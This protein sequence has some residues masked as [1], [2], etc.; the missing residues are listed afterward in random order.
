MSQQLVFRI[1]GQLVV[2]AGERTISVGGARQRTVLAMLLLSPDRVVS[3]DSLIKAVWQ[4]S[5]PSTS[6]NQIAICVSGLRKTFESEANVD[7]LIVTAHPGYILATGDHV[8]D[9]LEFEEEVR[10]GRELIRRGQ[11]AEAGAVLESALNLWRGPALDGINGAEEGAATLDEL[12]LDAYEELAGLRLQLGQHRSLIGELAGLVKE[13]PLREQARAHLILAHYRSGRRAEALEVFREARQLLVEELGIEPGPALQELHDQ[14]LRDAP[15]LTVRH[16]AAPTVSLPAQL[17]AGGAAFTG[18]A[19]QLALLDGLLDERRGH[20]PLAVGA[21]SG[22]SGVGKTALAVHWAHQVAEQFP[23]GQLFAD[24]RGYDEHDDPTAAS[25]VL[26]RFLRALGV[27]GPQVPTDPNERAAL[28]RSVLGSRRVLIV[29]DNAASYQQVRLLMPGN[30]RCCVL[31]TGRDALDG[32]TGDYAVRRIGLNVM[33][34]DEAIRLLRKVAGEERIA[35]DPAGA[36]LL[37]QL[38]DRLPL[39]L[40]I[41]GARLAAKPHWSVRTLV[42]RLSDQRLRLD[43][44]SQGDQGVRAGFRLSYRALPPAA[45]RM[46]R[47]LGLLAVPDFTS[48]VGAAVLDTDPA[49]AETLIEQLVDAQLLEVVT[50]DTDGAIRYRFQ[51]LLRLFGWECAQAEETEEERDAALDRAFGAWLSLA[52]AAHRRAHGGDYTIIHGPAPRLSL[53]EEMVDDLLADP[54]AWFE[55][56]RAAIVAVVE[57]AARTDRS[58]QAWDLTMSSSTLFS[59]HNYLEDWRTCA[60]HA[61]EAAR[62]TG[63]RIGEAAMLQSLGSLE[64]YQSRYAAAEAWLN[65]AQKLFDEQGEE[66]GLALVR[67]NLAL[68]G[69]FRGELGPALRHAEEALR[70]FRKVGDLMSESY[71]LGLMAQIE[72]ESGRVSEGIILSAEAVSMSRAAGFLRGEAQNTYRLAE[73]QMRNGEPA[74]AAEHCRT[75]LGLSRVE[76]DTVGEVFALRGLGEALWRQELLDDAQSC[77]QDALRVAED[78]ADRFLQARIRVDLGVILV[79]RGDGE[80]VGMLGRARAVF[81]DL[82]ADAWQRRVGRLGD[83]ARTVGPGSPVPVAELARLLDN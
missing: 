13:H 72:L 69:R 1:L 79:A 48:W 41:A 74:R 36:E 64:I 63:D 8:V 35:A 55:S 40:R 7:D 33:N 32:L 22:V 12:R 70:G 28:Y 42:N 52:D 61:L 14:V 67:R 51:D 78:L 15:E 21:I 18:R 16:I 39:A 25:A 5:P 71:V 81:T 58:A 57:Q 23:D 30:G 75:A 4:G 34:Q 50:G 38:C 9:S 62:R 66:H 44:L 59:T 53:P 3:V 46:Y 10:R 19:A 49:T 37:S 31:I 26:D 11:A 83:A 54:M 17:P 20:A 80:G 68:C 6:R 27:P 65:P 2:N 60:R 56:E 76:G 29:L 77:L 73:A 43:E 24:L 45:A 82:G 47:R